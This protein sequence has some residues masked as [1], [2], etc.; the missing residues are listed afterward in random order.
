MREKMNPHNSIWN[1]PRDPHIS[2]LMLYHRWKAIKKYIS[3]TV[4]IRLL[5][6][7]YTRNMII[8]NE[9]CIIAK[10]ST[11]FRLLSQLDWAH[12]TAKGLATAIDNNDIDGYY[13]RMLADTRSDPNQWNDYNKEMELK[14]HYAARANRASKI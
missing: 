13:E 6:Y 7:G 4:S 3:T 2:D 1:K 11:K 8:I 14:T 5:D 10:N 9:Q 12:Y